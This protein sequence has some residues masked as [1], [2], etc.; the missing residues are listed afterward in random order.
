MRIEKIILQKSARS[1][2]E[3]SADCLDLAQGQQ[4]LA[5]KTHELSA[6]QRKNADQQHALAA[7]QDSTANKLD[8]N[9]K[10]LDTMGRALEASAIETM[11]DTMVVPPPRD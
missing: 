8:E 9:A 3:K 7:K 2:L 4:N 1:L 11:G 10:K 6:E 5:D